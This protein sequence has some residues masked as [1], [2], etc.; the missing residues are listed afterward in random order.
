L[1]IR[2]QQKEGLH[3][4]RSPRVD[5]EDL[6]TALKKRLGEGQRKSSRSMVKGLRK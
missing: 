2:I 6:S 4:G 5:L 1:E 3:R